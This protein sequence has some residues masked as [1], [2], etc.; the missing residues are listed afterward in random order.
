M[1]TLLIGQQFGTEFCIT[2]CDVF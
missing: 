2:R 1:S